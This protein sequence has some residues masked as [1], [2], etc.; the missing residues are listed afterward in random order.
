LEWFLSPQSGKAASQNQPR[1][2]FTISVRGFY[3][4]GKTITKQ[5][6]RALSLIRSDRA[7]LAV[8]QSA[9]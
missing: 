2:T 4:R 1:E 7:A 9:C 5:R 6:G 8:A 3:Q